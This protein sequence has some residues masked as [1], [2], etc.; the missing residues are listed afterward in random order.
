MPRIIPEPRYF[1][2]PSIEVG[3]EVRMKRALNC[4]PWVWSLTHSPDAVIHSPAVIVAAWPMTVTRSRWPRAFARRTQKPFSLLWKVTR[5]TK[6]AS[7]SWVDGSCCGL[8]CVATVGASPPNRIW[9]PVLRSRSSS[10]TRAPRVLSIGDRP[11]VGN[12]PAIQILGS[13]EA[14]C[15]DGARCGRGVHNAG[16]TGRFIRTKRTMPAGRRIFLMPPRSV[17]V[18]AE[19]PTAR[20]AEPKRDHSDPG[21]WQRRGSIGLRG[22]SQFEPYHLHHPVLPNHRSPGRLQRGHFCGDFRR[23]HSA[24]SVSGETCGLSGR[25]FASRLCIQK[26]RSPRQGF[27]G[28]YLSAAGNIGR[29]WEAKSAVLSPVRNYRGFSPRASNCWLHSAG[30]SRSRSTPMP[31]G[32][33]PSTAARTRSGAKKASEIVMLT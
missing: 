7:A 16:S 4:W 3:A 6:P 30:A 2:M 31:R 23:Y 21:G 20:R 32:K 22:G 5:S 33:R 26:F 17:H 10:A 9:R 28:Q 27:H 15:D 13:L 12:R 8:I 25:I 29:S 14:A 19:V 18:R 24:L 1:S 11:L